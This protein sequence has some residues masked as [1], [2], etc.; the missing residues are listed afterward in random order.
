MD[1]AADQIA[2]GGV[3]WGGRLTA[4]RLGLGLQLGLYQLLN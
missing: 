2:K 3:G 1:R 4:Q